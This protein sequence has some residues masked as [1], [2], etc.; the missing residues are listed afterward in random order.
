MAIGGWRAA[1]ISLSRAHDIIAN[2]Q[3]QMRQEEGRNIAFDVMIQFLEQTMA[4]HDDPF[5]KRLQNFV[6]VS[7]PRL[8][9]PLNIAADQDWTISVFC[10]RI[11]LREERMVRVASY[12]K[13][14]A[15]T[16][17]DKR[18]WPKGVGWTGE[19]WRRAVEGHKFPWVVEADAASEESRNHYN[20]A[21]QEQAEDYERFKSVASI[22]FVGSN[23]DVCGVV[24]VTS[25]RKETFG[26]LKG[27]QGLRNFDMARSYASLISVLAAGSVPKL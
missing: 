3:H 1:E 12:W 26:G 21:G 17:K 25:G 14:S 7:A 5:E 8:I 19:A 22:P 16:K 13:E 24:T 11:V 18:S 9:G 15:R 10:K 4:I 27:T 23:G 2:L 20:T 6:S